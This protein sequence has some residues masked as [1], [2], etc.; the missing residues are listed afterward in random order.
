[1][2]KDVRMVMPVGGETEAIDSVQFVF[3]HNKRGNYI[4]VKVSSV[5][6]DIHKDFQVART[7]EYE[8]DETGQKNYIVQVKRLQ[9][10]LANAS[11]VVEIQ[12]EET[13][14]N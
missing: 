12:E 14:E 5:G 1:M 2:S 4:L 10:V 11:F 6:L 9:D 3:G 13:E 7:T 8:K